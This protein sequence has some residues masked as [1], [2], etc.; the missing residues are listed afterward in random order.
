MI[1]AQAHIVCSALLL[2]NSSKLKEIIGQ[3]DSRAKYAIASHNFQIT[4]L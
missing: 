4:K 2:Y 3:D 1:Y